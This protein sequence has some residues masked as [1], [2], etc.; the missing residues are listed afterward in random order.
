MVQLDDQTVIA[1]RPACLRPMHHLLF[2][3]KHVQISGVV[4]QP[5]LNGETVTTSPHTTRFRL[6][7]ARVNMQIA[8]DRS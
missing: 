6:S 7:A 4:S 2:V 1:L 3:G 5:E 8:G